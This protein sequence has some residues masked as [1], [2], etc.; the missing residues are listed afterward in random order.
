MKK[1][2]CIHLCAHS[3]FLVLPLSNPSPRR[4]LIKNLI[5][6]KGEYI[7]SYFLTSFLSFSEE[8]S[9]IVSKWPIVSNSDF[10][11]TKAKGTTKTPENS[12]KQGLEVGAGE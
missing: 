12:P 9:V 2:Q 5:F 3:V 1:Q 11:K 7:P 4:M 10:G 8:I 6:L